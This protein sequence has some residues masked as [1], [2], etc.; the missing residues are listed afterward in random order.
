MEDLSAIITELN[1][2]QPNDPMRCLIIFKT[3]IHIFNPMIQA[4]PD[5]MDE[6]FFQV[7]NNG[8]V[9]FSVRSLSNELDFFPQFL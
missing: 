4:V 6:G 2:R 8:F 7:I 5:D 1:R 3:G 9:Q